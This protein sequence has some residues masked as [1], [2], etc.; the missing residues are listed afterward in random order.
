MRV[1]IIDEEKN[2]G[3]TLTRFWDFWDGVDRGSMYQI[4]EGSNFVNLSPWQMLQL[5]S[6]FVSDNNRRIHQASMTRT[7]PEVKK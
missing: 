2:L 6:A 4:S 1:N 5:V 3:F 7:I